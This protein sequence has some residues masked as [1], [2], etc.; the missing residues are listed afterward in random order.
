M[1]SHDEGPH[2]CLNWLT[3]VARSFCQTSSAFQGEPWVVAAINCS[4]PVWR[5]RTIR[6]TL[7]C[8]VSTI[9]DD[10]LVS[11]LSSQRSDMREVCRAS[12]KYDALTRGRA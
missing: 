1:H 9:V 5:Q 7:W 2:T 6:S 12:N 3:W 11:T 4:C 10:V 8:R